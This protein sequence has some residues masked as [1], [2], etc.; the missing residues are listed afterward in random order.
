MLM[1]INFNWLNFPSFRWDF[2]IFI[3]LALTWVAMDENKIV[4]NIS[5]LFSKRKLIKFQ[6]EF[7]V[8]FFFLPLQTFIRIPFP[9]KRKLTSN[10][11]IFCMDKQNIIL[12]RVIDCCCQM[13][14]IWCVCRLSQFTDFTG[15]IDG[16]LTWR[17]WTDI[18]LTWQIHAWN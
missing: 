9:K 17:F 18:F 6:D 3:K 14:H 11:D 1:F 15:N 4:G 16:V 13:F 5:F 12:Q 2:W 10:S 8:Y 7:F